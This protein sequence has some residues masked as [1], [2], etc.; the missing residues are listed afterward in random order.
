MTIPYRTHELLLLSFFFL[1]SFS[2][3]FLVLFCFAFCYLSFIITGGIKVEAYYPYINMIHRTRFVLGALFFVRFP[4]PSNPHG[5][6]Q[7]IG[8]VQPHVIIGSQP[9]FYST[10]LSSLWYIN[11]LVASR[12]LPSRLFSSS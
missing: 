10:L 11:P 9:S 6:K 5:L 12:I 7:S 3:F 1:P 4:S 2:F 8:P